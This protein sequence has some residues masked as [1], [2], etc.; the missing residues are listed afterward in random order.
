MDNRAFYRKQRAGMINYIAF[1]VFI[2]LC[3]LGIT[4]F[5]LVFIDVN[6]MYPEDYFMLSFFP[7]V[8]IIWL[9]YFKT[10]VGGRRRKIHDKF[11]QLSN[12]EQMEI[13]AEIIELAEKPVNEGLY[14]RFGANRVYFHSSWFLEF[15]DYNDIVWI[16][17]SSVIG[18]LPLEIGGVIETPLVFTSLII[19]DCDRTRYKASVPP[20]NVSRHIKT[21]EENAPGAVIGYSKARKRLAKKDFDRFM[22]ESKDVG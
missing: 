12:A 3:V 11:E 20:Q 10:K 6:N 16:Y 17:H 7:F 15:V 22:L 13:N 2:G 14:I 9:I 18:Q 21:L 4:R 8:Y 19:W 1:I 5:F